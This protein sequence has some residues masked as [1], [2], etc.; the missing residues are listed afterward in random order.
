[1]PARILR[2]V[3]EDVARP[4]HETAAFAS[5]AGT[6]T[7]FQF[8]RGA[9]GRRYV[10]SVYSLIE[11]P[12]FP[13]VTYLLVRA[14]RDGTRTVLH[15]GH[16]SDLSQTLNLARVRMRGAQLGAN[17]VHLHLLSETESQR[18]LVVCDLRAG[19]LGTLGAECA[20]AVQT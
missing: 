8:W 19:L 18:Q 3:H 15:V 2:P 12:P 14:E 1:M 6:P 7:R 9:S 20:P 5:P 17:E 4:S 10:H 11:C 13:R 16:G